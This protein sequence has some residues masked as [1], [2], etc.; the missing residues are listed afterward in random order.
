M[1]SDVGG[2]TRAGE[3]MAH[4]LEATVLLDRVLSP[5]E[6][7]EVVVEHGARVLGA[8]AAIVHVLSPSGDALLSLHARGYPAGA[9]DQWARIPLSADLPTTDAVRTR[10]Q[11]AI[12]SPAELVQR[13]PALTAAA[14][15]NQAWLIAPLMVGERIVGTL[16]L[17]FPNARS[18][19]AVDVGFATLLSRECAEALDRARLRREAAREAG[20]TA[21]LRALADELSSAA[22]VEDVSRL[23][24]ARGILA[25]GAFAGVVGELTPDGTELALCCM[26]GY[27]DEAGRLLRYPMRT[28][29]ALGDAARTGRPLL[30]PSRAA[31]LA[32][33]PHLGPILERIGG[34]AA[35]ALPLIVEGRSVGALGLDF[36]TDRELDEADRGVLVA[37]AQQCAQALARARLYDE[38]RRAERR[39]RLVADASRLLAEAQ[40]DQAAV[41]DALCRSVAGAIGDTCTILLVGPDGATM[42]PVAVED[43]D[44]TRR[45]LRRAILAE[46]PLRVGEGIAG[47]VAA[48]GERV[49]VREASWDDFYATL[50][51]EYRPHAARLFFRSLVVVPLRGHGAPV[52]TLSVERITTDD[53]LDER[54]ADVLE[55][56]GSR[57]ALAI[58]NARLYAEAQ[59][60]IRSRDQFL[61]IAAHELKTPL[62][63][64]KGNAQYLLAAHRTGRLTEERL[65]RT[66]TALDAASSRLGRLTDDLLDVSRIRSGRLELRPESTNLADL[67]R[68]AVERHRD[69][70][71]E[72]HHDVRA[73]VP[74]T[75]CIASADPA[76]LE[77]VFENLLS[78]A[79][80][81][82]PNG[83]TIDVVLESA[84]GV[85]RLRVSDEGIG[86][87]SG[88]AERVFE[89]FGR[90][91]NAQE[92][93]LP[94]MGLGLYI[95]RGIVE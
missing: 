4:L 40:L 74:E 18:F 5:D 13:Y 53:P 51:P 39:Q 82:S 71:D 95:C 34:G 1:A 17:A 32:V 94:G 7:A 70:L 55:E 64:V 12:G 87:P 52:G 85:A 11:V 57:A 22:T 27:P 49:L 16:S 66:L 72:T 80:K 10:Q 48:S 6:V 47:R 25:L 91:S 75:P 33:Y 65:A 50:K 31:R 21:T 8:D 73:S 92:R 29:T 35:A 42:V 86:L 77:E 78:N 15:V 41:L 81:Y 54:E 84:S 88:E 2:E 90:A 68:H 36:P 45:D 30:F 19:D 38:A 61:S 46:H 79:V 56:I 3:R 43:P 83:G 67:V 62:T 23:V 59:G 89:P 76:R 58:E 44:P 69:Y 20:R 37:L 28:P 26:I 93:H 24:V 9:I 14:A 63:A 60:A